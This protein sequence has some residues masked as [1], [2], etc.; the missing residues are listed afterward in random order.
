MLTLE[1]LRKRA[2]ARLTALP[3]LLYA[4]TRHWFVLLACVA[5][6]TGMAV[7]KVKT[8][9]I[10]YRGSATL[11]LNDSAERLAVNLSRRD[12]MEESGK[13][14]GSRIE[15]LQ[16]ESVLRRVVRELNPINILQQEENVELPAYGEIRQ[17]V[18]LVRQ[19]LRELQEFLENPNPLDTNE[20]IVLQR[21]VWSFQRRIR[22]EPN[23]RLSTVK[24]HVFGNNRDAIARELERWIEAYRERLI[25]VAKESNS[26]FFDSRERY[27]QKM[28]ES[29]QL[30]LDNFKKEHPDVSKPAQEILFRQLY[31]REFDLEALS[32]ERDSP[33][34]K[35][36]SLPETI[37]PDPDRQMWQTRLR[38]LRLELVTIEATQGSS[39]DKADL[40]RL[41]I[42]GFED[43]LSG[44]SSTD[45]K[46][47]SDDPDQRL[48]ELN[49]RYEKLAAYVEEIRERYFSLSAR[50]EEKIRL[51]DELRSTQKMRGDYQSSILDSTE[52]IEAAKIAQISVQDKPNVDYQPFNTYPH[53]QVLFGCLGG[54]GLGLAIALLLELL[55]PRVRFKH[56]IYTEFGVPVIGVIPRR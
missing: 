38:E 17:F 22:V 2:V 9:P 3:E 52:R 46:P 8:D 14:F 54:L 32:R 40:I 6:G 30:A 56:D 55:S 1:I 50:L 23:A 26:P 18:N 5:V 33:Q 28:E 45:G 36:L 21:A 11:A 53:R 12:P 27:W 49:D 4:F 51:E 15:M 34:L 19:K 16:N 10:V 48:G 44:I 29:A 25:E 39:S 42:K 35:S 13:F 41:Q 24:I 20:D 37:Q 31:Q 47:V 43:K 7:A